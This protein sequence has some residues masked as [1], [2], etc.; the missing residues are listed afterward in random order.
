MKCTLCGV[1][2]KLTVTANVKEGHVTIGYKRLCFPCLLN[3]VGLM[4]FKIFDWDRAY[5]GGG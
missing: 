3:E 5:E 4:N 2:R 1:K